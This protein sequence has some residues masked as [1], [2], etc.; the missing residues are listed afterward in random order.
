[1]YNYVDNGWGKTVL[2]QFIKILLCFTLIYTPFF[3][4]AG[5]A[6][7][8]EYE[9]VMKDMNIHVKGY[10][11]DQYGNAAND[12][13][14]NTK[15]DP[16][17]TA[18]KQKMGTVGFGRLLKST[19]WG[20]LGAAALEALLE[21]VDWVLDP[22]SQSIWRN[23]KTDP[24][25]S[26]NCGGGYLFRYQAGEWKSCPIDA[27][28]P[29]LTEHSV[30][31]FT[32]KFV[33]FDTDPFAT[34]TTAIKF[35]VNLS[36][37][38]LNLD[39]PNQSLDRKLDPNA[40]PQPKEYLTP[41]TLAD[42]ANHTHPDYSNP[43]LAPKLEPKYSPKIAEDLWKPSNE[44]EK[45]NSPTVQEVERKLDQAQPE[46]KK[47]PEITPNPE[48]G[49]SVL[50]SFCS[51]AV[52]V[53]DFIKWVKE[54]PENED[55][56]PEI[57]QEIDIGTLDTG[58]FKATAGCPAPI[59]VPVNLGTGGNVEISYEP[60]CQFAEKWSFVAPLIGF[61]SG[62]MILVGVGRKGEDGEI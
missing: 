1:M 52:T 32:Y 48:T 14:Y 25:N 30:N 24:N 4:F 37:N 27:I 62:A 29:Y 54:N 3:A 43:E 55:Q 40:Q 10:K 36:G 61:L 50:P 60:I 7:K 21:S 57:P 8:W 17:T 6:E 2:K 42:Y 19:G 9:P 47:E 49:G 20:L 33:R 46:P 58:T 53:C 41:E 18:N 13:E 59:Q 38:G 15:I 26:V 23:K 34:N 16:K 39:T 31:G 51:W 44:W 11:V 45:E 28:Q 56:A 12:Y 5:A 22:E 35:T